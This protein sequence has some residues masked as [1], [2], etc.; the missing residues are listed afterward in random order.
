M[1]IFRLLPFAFCLFLFSCTEEIDITLR[2]GDVR[3]V[4]EGGI[5]IDTTSHRI[6]LSRTTN[7][8]E[9][10]KEP[11]YVEGATVTITEFDE[12]MQPT[13]RIFRLTETR[14]GHYYTDDTV[15]GIQRHTYRLT[16]VL[17]EA[18]GGHTTYTADAFFPPIADQIDGLM[19]VRGLNML[20]EELFP[21]MPI[22][23]TRMGWNLLLWATD[24]P[25]QNFY[26]FI[27]SRNGIALNDTLTQFL[28]LDNSIIAQVGQGLAG[29]PIAFIPDDSPNAVSSGDTLGMEIRGISAEYYRW[30][31]EFRDIYSGQNPM[32][33]GAPANIR[34]NI[35]G[36]AI[37]FFWAH[38]NRRAYV[39]A[40]Q[41]AL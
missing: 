31:R 32:F 21:G 41:S 14:P 22:D 8:F 9:D 35:S 13:G 12:N 3:L 23:T 28:M 11:L 24:P 37:G 25:G 19:A 40:G 10:P 5:G 26:V 17:N 15:F 30:I 2:P 6:I 18:I 34:G 38:G 33:G 27:T 16:I 29:L 36:G 39:V 20:V 4:L 7:F 1:K